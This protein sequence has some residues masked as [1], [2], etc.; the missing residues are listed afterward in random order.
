MEKECA[1]KKLIKD[2]KVTLITEC[3]VC[4]KNRRKDLNLLIELCKTVSDIVKKPVPQYNKTVISTFERIKEAVESENLFVVN[5]SRE[6]IKIRLSHTSGDDVVFKHVPEHKEKDNHLEDALGYICPKF[7]EKLTPTI[8]DI[9]YAIKKELEE[10]YSG[11]IINDETRA[12]MCFDGLISKIPKG[13]SIFHFKKAEL[14]NNEDKKCN[15]WT[16]K[17]HTKLNG[18]IGVFPDYNH[19]FDLIDFYKCIQCEKEYYFK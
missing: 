10:Q 1:C 6:K 5:E 4:K 19:S 2:D 15:C 12:L 9:S 11:T 8:D 16:L 14:V 17:K 7:F 13:W 18:N 3:N